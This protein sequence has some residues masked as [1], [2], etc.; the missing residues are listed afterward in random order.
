MDALAD[1]ANR[2]LLSYPEAMYR[3]GGIG[4]TKFFEI[5]PE[6]EKVNIGRRTFVTAKSVERYVNQLSEQATA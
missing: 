3:L 2:L 4:R 5:L 1:R 6:L